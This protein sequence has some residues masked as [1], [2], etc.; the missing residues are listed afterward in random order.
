VQRLRREKVEPWSAA[1]RPSELVSGARPVELDADTIRRQIDDNLLLGQ[2]NSEARAL[3]SQEAEAMLCPGGEFL[4]RQGDPADAMYLVTGG[5][6]QVIAHHSDGTE[7]QVGEIGRGEVVGEMALITREPRTASVQAVR[8]TQLLRVSADTFTRLVS[9]HPEALRRVSGTIVAR[10]MRTFRG[11][12]ASSPVR[13]ITVVAL[14]D[15]EPRGFAA[16]LADAIEGDVERLDRAKVTEALGAKGGTDSS[17]LADYIAGEEAKHDVLVYD[18]GTDDPEW[19]ELCVRQ[20]DLLLLVADARSRPT[21]RPI[22]E[23]VA[24]VRGSRRTELVLLHAAGTQRASGTRFWLGPRTVRHHHHVRD[25][26]PPDVARVAR[27]VTG[28]G[29]GLVLG[30]GGARGL[31][32]LGVLRA[33]EDLAI[34]IDAVAG[35]SMG[36]LIAA[37]KA[38]EME[39]AARVRGMRSAVVEGPSALDLTFPVVSLASGTRITHALQD[40]FGELHID[41]LWLA[42]FCVS[43]NLTQGELVVHRDGPVWRALRASFAIP[44]IFPPIREGRDLL[45]DGGVL[46]NLPVEEMQRQHDGGYVIAVD[47][48]NKRDLV[49]GDLPGD[50]IVSGWRALFERLNPLAPAGPSI[51]ITKILMRLTE[52]SSGFGSEAELADLVVRPPVGAFGLMDF[53]SLDRLVEVGHQAASAQLSEWLASDEAPAALRS[54]GGPAARGAAHRVPGG[55]GLG[56]RRSVGFVDRGS[57]GTTSACGVSA[58]AICNIE[59]GG[60]SSRS[61]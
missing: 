53:R 31:A 38:L 61:R 52:L 16:R 54:R 22:E 8:D 50:G 10:Y 1:D 2:L 20:A 18:T 51:G 43:C 19:T 32:H 7:T 26:H 58:G 5:R 47:V 56:A 49:A 17:H 21:P 4:L 36:S 15:G 34:P 57:G 11:A 6:L 39:D 60:S 33:L 40:F 13:T 12:T 14:D 59:A 35:S 46:D 29:I 37:G 3:V 41:D 9:E 25:R 45:V 23:R 55:P 27:L 28:K 48:S 30:G 24:A 44:G 42:Y